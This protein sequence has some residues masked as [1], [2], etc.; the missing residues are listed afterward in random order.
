MPLTKVMVDGFEV[1][2]FWPDL[3]LLV[4]TDGWRYHRTPSAQSRDAL[5]FQ[6]HIASGLTPLR[7]SHYQVKYQPGHVVDILRKT[8]TNL[9]VKEEP[10]SR[11]GRNPPL[12]TS[13][14][15]GGPNLGVADAVQAKVWGGVRMRAL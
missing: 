8:L 15:Y 4:E 7:F 11:T 6:R 3:G 14:P 13:G 5:R 1:D 12:R 2:F 9:R 10:R